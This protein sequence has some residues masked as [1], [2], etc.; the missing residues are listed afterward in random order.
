MEI[1]PGAG[2]RFRGFI[3]DTFREGR[4]RARDGIFL[5]GYEQAA[6][7]VD[8]FLAERIASL[9]S[10][11]RAGSLTKQEQAMLAELSELREAIPQRLAQALGIHPPE[12]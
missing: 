10:K 8:E 4:D 1:Q 12:L 5:D 9:H 7:I 6:G 11:A 2:E 3:K